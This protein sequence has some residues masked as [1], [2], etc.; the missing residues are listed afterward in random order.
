MIQFNNAA[1][2]P[3]DRLFGQFV[4]GTVKRVHQLHLAVWNHGKLE[5]NRPLVSF[6]ENR[7][8]LPD[9]HGGGAI[10]LSETAAGAFG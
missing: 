4:D 9:G 8:R 3:R 2:L 5:R 1:F 7:R 6:R 10:G